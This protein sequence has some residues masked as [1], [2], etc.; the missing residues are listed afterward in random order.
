MKGCMVYFS[1]TGNTE[2][3]AKA[4][5]N[6]FAIKNISC[7]L[8]EVSKNS[9][10][11]DKYDF[12]VFGSPIYAELF[13]TF[14][15][16]WVKKHIT[17]GNGRKCIVYSTQANSIACGPTTFSKEL[18]QIGFEIVIEDCITMPNNYYLVMFE[19]FTDQQV[20]DALMKAKDRA[21]LIVDNFMNNKTHL[22]NAKGREIWGKPVFKLFMLWSRKWAKK[23]LVVD[24]SKCTRCG[25]CQK[26]CPVNNIKVNKDSI[27]FSDNCTSCQRCVHKC[28]ANAFLYKNKTIDQYKLPKQ[29]QISKIS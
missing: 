27:A 29:E 16:E 7:D 17:K 23:G 3:V 19:K 25:L 1:A 5:R 4:I 8:Y 13:P 28:P 6:E 12:Y 2:Y 24:M 20:N 11:E 26:H 10:F 14:Y 15:T 18:K 21:I 22:N 9:G